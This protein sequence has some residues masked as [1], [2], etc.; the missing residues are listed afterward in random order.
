MASLKQLQAS[1]MEEQAAQGE[2]QA[3]QLQAAEAQIAKL[4]KALAHRTRAVA[5]IG[6]VC[7]LQDLAVR[8]KAV[9]F[10]E[11]KMAT[12]QETAEATQRERDAAHEAPAT[13]LH[14]ARVRTR[15]VLLEGGA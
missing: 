10:F 3:S 8:D 7:G 9:Q 12:I 6:G 13:P 14:G 1:H 4:V 11:N 2:S 15:T 5:L